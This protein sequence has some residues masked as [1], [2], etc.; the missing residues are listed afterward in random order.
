MRKT[1]L[2]K[3]AKNKVLERLRKHVKEKYIG[4]YGVVDVIGKFKGRYLYIEWVEG[5]TKEIIDDIKNAY[6]KFTQSK[7]NKIIDLFKGYQRP[8]KL[9]RLK[10][11]GDINHWDFEIYKYSDMWYDTDKEFPFGGG[12]VEECFD[13][14]DSLYITHTFP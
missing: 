12:T 11:T 1:T 10:Y 9:C 4:K 6:P 13:A 14:A 7:I 2:S 8:S 5:F 3:D